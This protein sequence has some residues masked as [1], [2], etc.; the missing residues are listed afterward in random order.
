ME[1][2]HVD[3]WA[4]TTISDVLTLLAS[5]IGRRIVQEIQ[6]MSESSTTDMTLIKNETP[7]ISSG[8]LMLTVSGVQ[9][10]WFDMV[11][12]RTNTTASV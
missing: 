7:I 4:R 6:T 8:D 9:E 5:C 1:I 11:F 2:A 12:A 3:P 10:D